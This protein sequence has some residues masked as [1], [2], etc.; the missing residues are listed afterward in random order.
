M[1]HT[2]FLSI[3]AAALL[4][5]QA[6]AA[7]YIPTTTDATYID[8]QMRM[9]A[10][11]YSETDD[12][13]GGDVTINEEFDGGEDLSS[14]HVIGGFTKGT[15]KT[16]TTNTVT[17]DGGQ[18]LAVCGGYCLG[19]EA[20]TATTN[21]VTITG[22]QVDS[23][24]WGGF[25]FAGDAI[26][27]TVNISGG[28]VCDV[29]GGE[30]KKATASGNTVTITGG[31]VD[32]EVFGGSGSK[33]ANGNTVTIS[34]ATV[35]RDVIGGSSNETVNGN[36]VTISRATVNGDVIGGSAIASGTGTANDNTVVLSSCTVNGRVLAVST[37]GTFTGNAIELYGTGISAAALSNMQLLNFHIEG[38]APMINLTSTK[39]DE[40][41]TLSGV[42]L[43]FMGETVQDWSVFDGKSITLVVAAQPIT[44]EEGSLGNVEIKAEDGAVIATATLGLENANKS[45]VLSDIKAAPPVPEP[46]TGSLSLLALAGLCARRR[47][48]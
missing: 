25:S 20:G 35:N 22:G 39:T 9:H 46:A 44:V 14:S 13:S 19:D 38:D 18:V 24:V 1:K 36:T 23:Q 7:E 10:G 47:K 48:T 29:C 11:K 41:L 5:G 37:G 4:G 27:N 8:E 40:A 12:V 17:M 31:Q 15:D 26:N 6:H 16:A 28:Q 21:T 33:T 2:L 30:T 43:G 34:C 42:T 45:L 3:L 32:G